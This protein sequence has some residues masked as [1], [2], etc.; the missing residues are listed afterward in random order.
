MLSMADD[1]DN[2]LTLLIAHF[3]ARGHKTGYHKK[4]SS[5]EE[6]QSN[7]RYVHCRSTSTSTQRERY[8][9]ELWYTIP[10]HLQGDNT[11]NI[12][13]GTF[14]RTPEKED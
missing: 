4:K 14:V 13:R 12:S 9:N 2:V 11:R 6:W 3:L 5:V 10:Y 8:Y 7:T 1:C